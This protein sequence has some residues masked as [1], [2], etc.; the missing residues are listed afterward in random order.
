[1]LL[2]CTLGLTLLFASQP[3]LQAHDYWLEPETFFP[4][5]GQRIALRLHLGD[6]FTSEDERPLQRQR[7]TVYQLLGG[8]RTVNLLDQGEEGKTPSA[9]L[10]APAAGTYL[11]RMDRAPQLIKLSAEKFNKYLAEEGLESILELRRKAGEDKQPGRER[12]SRCLKALLQAGATHDD[13]WQR[14]LGQT[15][16]I[17]PL[18]NPYN[19]K[20]DEELPVRV[21]FEGK[22]LGGVKLFAHCRTGAKVRTQTVVTTKDGTAT[23]QLERHG[24]WLLRLVHMRRNRGDDADWESYWGALTFA[25]R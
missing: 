19:R 11:V 18:A 3:S 1:M 24:V 16:E 25:L 5:V 2:R 14:V 17:V 9:W 15:L 4:A 6:G 12:Y 10:T 13:T 23:V 20:V 21:L 7:T 22:P 8:G